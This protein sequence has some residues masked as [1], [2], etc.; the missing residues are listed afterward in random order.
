LA[1]S[2]MDKQAKLEQQGYQQYLSHKP[3]KSVA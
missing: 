1:Q 3:W 2:V